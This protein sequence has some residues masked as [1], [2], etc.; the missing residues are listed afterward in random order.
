MKPHLPIVPGS[1]SRR[2]IR[3]M[4]GNEI[5]SLIAS[6]VLRVGDQLPSERDLAE[7]LNV[8]RETVR[9]SL[10]LL[11]ERGIVTISRG[12]RAKV[13]NVKFEQPTVGT[14]NSSS[15]SGYN[16]EDVFDARM[17]IE[18]AV[19]ADATARADKNLVARLEVILD[20]QKD[21]LDDPI[22]F[23]VCDRSFHL[24]IYRHCGNKLMSNMAVD[25]FTY[26]LEQRRQVFEPERAHRGFGDHVK[27]VDAIRRGD[28]EEAVAASK[29][30]LDRQ[31]NASRTGDYALSRDR[32]SVQP[33]I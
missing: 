6:G 24:T 1:V 16:I 4:L 33:A 11:A 26:M 5:E 7:L 32:N 29:L 2:T 21:A 8:S 9:R 30:H 22:Q 28:V 15:I 10:Q 25:L 18:S 3:D 20:A 12:K 19:V 17:L 27:M 31:Y 23:F 13:K 14:M